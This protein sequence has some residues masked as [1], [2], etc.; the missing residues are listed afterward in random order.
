MSIRFKNIVVSETNYN[1]LKKLGD[2][3]ESFNDVITDILKKVQGS[4]QVMN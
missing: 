2:A 4:H 1:V 3:G